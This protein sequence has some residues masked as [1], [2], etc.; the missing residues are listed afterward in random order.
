[1]NRFFLSLT[2]FL[3]LTQFLN[4]N[5]IPQNESCSADY[6]LSELV[7]TKSEK[8]N[9]FNYSLNNQQFSGTVV[10][11]L[12]G[13]ETCNLFYIE[14]GLISKRWGFFQNGNL[15]REEYFKNGIPHG[16]CLVFFENGKK[17][18][19]SNYKNGILHGTVKTWREDGSQI[20]V[21]KYSMGN[22]ISEKF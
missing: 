15:S 11:H 17:S 18:S 6:L 19:E 16:R 14:N 9:I 10:K 21:A 7:S 3:I 8:D 12:D 4:P 2:T 20:R 13:P 22:L 1:M 5:Q